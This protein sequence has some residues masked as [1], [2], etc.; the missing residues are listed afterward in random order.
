MFPD[1]AY[2]EN[3]LGTLRI[4][5]GFNDSHNG[6]T[7]SR[8][9]SMDSAAGPPTPTTAYYSSQSHINSGRRSLPTVI[10]TDDAEVGR[11]LSPYLPI[12]QINSLQN[13][14]CIPAGIT[15][16]PHLPILSTKPKFPFQMAVSQMENAELRDMVKHLSQDSVDSASDEAEL[17]E[18]EFNQNVWALMARQWLTQGKQ[19]QCPAH[20]MLVSAKPADGR[21]I[22]NVHRSAADGWVLAAKYP[23]V[24]VFTLSTSLTDTVNIKSW[25]TPPNL[26]T[27]FAPPTVGHDIIFPFPNDHFDVIISRDF[28]TTVKSASWLSTLRECHRILS[29]GGWLEIQSLTPTSLISGGGKLLNAWVESQ[30]LLAMHED[31]LVVQSPSERIQEHIGT[32]G[33][34]DI[35]TARIALPATETGDQD[36][37]RLMVLAGRH[38]YAQLY[39]EFLKAAT[40][41]RG[42]GEDLLT[43]VELPWWWKNG[44][45]RQECENERAMFGFVISFGR[46]ALSF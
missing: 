16:T 1:N 46:K 19:L 18:L 15:N 3:E 21:R 12:P 28:S 32:A 29:P 27:V 22:L 35:K 45:I 24:N 34:T 6:L 40:E 26:H 4:D 23:N 5:G 38:Y 7:I 31:G 20:E 30:I 41:R 10:D 33:F 42:E 8:S 13:S 2:D 11:F 44:S 14:T 39:G 36:A 17:Q 37:G 25:P 9:S 43:K